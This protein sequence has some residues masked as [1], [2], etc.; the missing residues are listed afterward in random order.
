[1]S[2]ML[3]EKNRALFQYHNDLSIFTLKWNDK[4]LKLCVECIVL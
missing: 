3:S 1:M 4:A 2:K